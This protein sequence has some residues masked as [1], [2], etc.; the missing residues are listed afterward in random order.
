MAAHEAALDRHS[1]RHDNGCTEKHYLHYLDTLGYQLSHVE[2]LAAGLG[3]A[4][5]D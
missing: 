3:A 1:W 2:R 4:P 5:T